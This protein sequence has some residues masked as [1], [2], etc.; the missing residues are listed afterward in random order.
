MALGKNRPGELFVIRNIA[1]L[2]P[3]YEENGT[4]HS[5]SAAI[6][7]AVTALKVKQIVILGRGLCGGTMA[8]MAAATSMTAP[9]CNQ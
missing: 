1:A 6:E 2:V 3:P 5:T 7:F 4:Y 9:R 8:S